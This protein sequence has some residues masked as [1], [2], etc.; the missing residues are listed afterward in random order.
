M[1]DPSPYAGQTVKL[2]PD[3]AELGG[4]TAEVIDW[5]D[6]LGDS[7]SWHADPANP[8][9]QNYAIR[10]ALGG[11]PDDDDVLMARVDGMGQLI[12][13]TEIEGYAPP[14]SRLKA[15]PLEARDIGALCPACEKSIEAEQMVSILLLGP[16]GNP[17]ERE[18]ARA[19]QPYNT[20]AIEVHWACRT[21][22]ESYDRK[23]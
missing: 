11:L 22:D 18:K 13:A 6:R 3:A 1:R 7:I 20:C 12:H 23:G 21:G 16:G 17:A 5:F 15:G 14:L 4:H 9:V 10:R 8:R 19:G 2:R